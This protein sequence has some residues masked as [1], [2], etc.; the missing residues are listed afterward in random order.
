[1]SASRLR[2]ALAVSAL[3]L[4]LG[5]CVA[6]AI[7][8]VAGGAIATRGDT[9]EERSDASLA[10]PRSEAPAAPSPTLGNTPQSAP[11]SPAPGSLAAEAQAATLAVAS[12]RAGDYDAFLAHATAQA[13]R[14]PIAAPRSSAILTAPGSLTPTTT[15]C[16]ILPPAVVID[17]DPRGATLDI[18]ALAADPVL[19]RG[20]AAL[21]L[22]GVEVNWISNASAGQAGALRTRLRET[23]L[24]P[25]ARDALLLMRRATDRKQLRRKELSQTHCVVAIAGDERPDFDELFGYLKDPSAA[26]DLEPLVGDRWFLV[27]TLQDTKED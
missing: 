4:S 16:A 2:A 22:Q 5:G 21:R 18:A 17:L 20:L 13:A 9:D 3:A 27:S 14:D 19:A 15:E 6:A 23:G 8:L 12:G 1:M 7:P 26:A 11:A 24:D 25:E 10:T